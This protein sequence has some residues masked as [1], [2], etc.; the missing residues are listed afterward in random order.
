MNNTSDMVKHLRRL[1]GI[2]LHPTF[3]VLLVSVILARK[4]ILLLIFSSKPDSISG[5]RFLSVQ[6][7]ITTALISAF[8]LLRET[9]CLSARSS[10]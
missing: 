1:S 9:R 10:W 7:E 4:P 5:R 8:P 2:L 3:P 6:P